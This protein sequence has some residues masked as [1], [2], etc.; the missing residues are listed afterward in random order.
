MGTAFLA[1]FD[2]ESPGL[3]Y[4]YSF[5]VPVE[6]DADEYKTNSNYN[7]VKNYGIYRLLNIAF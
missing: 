7:Q 6:G 1:N 3:I 4:K 2:I 5:T